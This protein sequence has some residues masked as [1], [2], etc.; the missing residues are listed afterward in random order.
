[1]VVRKMVS[2]Y[3]WSNAVVS[4]KEKKKRRNVI[5]LAKVGIEK[6]ARVKKM[7]RDSLSFLPYYHNIQSSMCTYK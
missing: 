1:M 7:G 4:G 5:I 3:V 6:R 2:I